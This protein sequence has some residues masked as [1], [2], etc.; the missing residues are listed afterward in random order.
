MFR[1]RIHYSKNQDLR[2]TSNLDMHKVWERTL[3]RASLPLAYS[4]GFHPQ[5]R[6]NQACPLPLGF[7]SQAEIIEIWLTEMLSIPDLIAKIQSKCPVG[8]TVHDIQTIDLRN[9][10]IPTLVI[11][12]EYQANLLAACP[13]AGLSENLQSLLEATTIP[14]TRREKQYDLRPLIIDLSFIQNPSLN[15]QILMTLSA[16]EGAT[17]RPEEILD[18]LNIPFNTVLIERTNLIL[19]EIQGD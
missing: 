2:Y 16:K 9:P 11:A 7:I 10:S 3:R 1:Y 17:G 4:Q 19:S 5:P 8:I 13:S 12:S 6:I 14:R 18:C 15:P